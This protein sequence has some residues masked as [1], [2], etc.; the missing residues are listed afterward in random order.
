M[1]TIAATPSCA[2]LSRS[3]VF[4]DFHH[5]LTIFGHRLRLRAGRFRN[6][7][8]AVRGVADQLRSSRRDSSPSD[9]RPAHSC[10]R[11]QRSRLSRLASCDFSC[12]RSAQFSDAPTAAHMPVSRHQRARF[13]G[14][15]AVGCSRGGDARSSRR[16]PRRI[17]GR[18]GRRSRSLREGARRP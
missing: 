6:R 11:A 18:H 10:G 9:R 17:R 4:C 16:R 13:D 12:Q 15:F 7:L 2:P 14:V 3:S 5:I 1:Y 8:L